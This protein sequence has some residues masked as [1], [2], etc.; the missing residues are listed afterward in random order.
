MQTDFAFIL[1]SDG[2]KIRKGRLNVCSERIAYWP[3]QAQALCPHKLLKYSAP[4]AAWAFKSFGGLLPNEAVF[5]A[6]RRTA[7][8]EHAVFSDAVTV[9]ADTAVPYM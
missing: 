9:A 2:M 6:F 7:L 3:F 1:F 4:A 5:Y 8:F